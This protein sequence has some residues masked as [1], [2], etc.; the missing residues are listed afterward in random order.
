MLALIALAGTSAAQTPRETRSNWK[1]MNAVMR[2]RRDQ[3]NGTP[4]E[5]CSLYAALGRP[6][7]FPEGVSTGLRPLLTS[8]DAS[9]CSGEVQ[10][11]SHWIEVPGGVVLTDSI[12]AAGDTSRVYTHVFR[13][14]MLSDETYTFVRRADGTWTGYVC[15]YQALYITPVRTRSH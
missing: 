15:I 2:L 9:R 5:V 11:G 4:F 13:Y 3:V 12:V 14:E 1:L 6:A 7:A 8:P 10:T